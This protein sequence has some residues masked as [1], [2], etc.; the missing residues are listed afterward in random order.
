MTPQIPNE[1]SGYR[2]TFQSAMKLT[3]IIGQFFG[4]NPVIGV[5]ET[6]AT[7]LRLVW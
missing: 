4:L 2:V 3:I 6:D 5:S 7:K 1:S